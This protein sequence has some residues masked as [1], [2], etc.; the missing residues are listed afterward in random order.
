MS[1]P[2]LYI[3]RKGYPVTTHSYSGGETFRRCKRAYKL[4]RLDGW[5]K[6]AKMASK[7]FGICIENAI[8][9]FHANGKLPGSSVGA[10][11]AD[12][13]R[14]KEQIDLQ[15][16]DKEGSWEDLLQMG[17]DLLRLYEI[18]L[19]SLPWAS[20]NAIKF[21][22]NYR[23]EVF[24]GTYLGG[25]NFTAFVDMRVHIPDDPPLFLN[26]KPMIVDIKTSATTLDEP[27][28]MLDPQ[29]RSYAWVTGTPDVAFLWF[30]KGRPGL[31]KGDQITALYDVGS[32]KAGDS[33]LVLQSTDDGVYFLSSEHF[34]EYEKASAGLRGKVADALRERTKETLASVAPTNF[35]TK[36]RLQFAATHISAEDMKEAGE[37]IGAEIAEIHMANEKGWWPKEPSIRFPDQKCKFCALRGNCLGDK[38]LRDDLVVRLDEDWLDKLEEEAA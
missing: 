14:R 20:D 9:L 19:P 12:W 6:R 15:Y 22:L 21:Q 36:C 2:V 35:V 1:D 11:E 32:F 37:A 34:T 17:R 26:L 38:K 33:A 5:F 27:M 18:K 4:E 13:Q 30:V 16:T 25:I 10:F 23:K 29:L 31:K 8:Q 28:V 3:N 7:E 24:P